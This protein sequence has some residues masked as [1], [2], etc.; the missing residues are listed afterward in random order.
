MPKE[1]SLCMI[2]K[3]EENNLKRCLNSVKDLV[4]EIIILD[5]GSTDNT[6]AIASEYTSKIFYYD[7][8]NDFSN[9]RNNSL[10]YATKDFIFIMDADDELD[11]NDR[12]K[13]FNLKN[14]LDDSETIYYFQTISHLS[15]AFNS[16]INS[17][18]NLMPRLFKNNTKY[19]YKNALHEQLKSDVP[20]DELRKAILDIHIFHYGYLED[21]SIDKIKFN[22]NIS[23]LEKQLLDEPNEP[24]HYFNLGNEY[25]SIRNFEEA[26]KY[27]LI[28]YKD[29]DPCKGYSP[30]LILKLVICY[31]SLDKAPECFDMIEKGLCIYPT[32]SD[33]HY[34]KGMILFDKRLYSQAIDEFSSCVDLGVAPPQLLYV[35]DASP[36]K[37]YDMISRCY[38]KLNNCS[39]AFEFAAKAIATNPKYV[40]PFY[41]C[42]KIMVDDNLSVDNIESILLSFF[43]NIKENSSLI[44]NIFYM[45]KLYNLSLKYLNIHEDNFQLSEEN[46]ILKIKLLLKLDKLDE[47][48]YYIDLISPDSINFF[49]SCK[50]KSILY[51]LK[52]ENVLAM[53]TIHHFS[54]AS[55][56]YQQK[57]I[58]VLRE[59]SNLLLHKKGS[60]I[61]D[62][63]DEI[64]SDIIFEILEFFL[65]T[66]KFDEF[67]K[68]LE[69]LNLIDDSS[70]LLRL[71]KL[72]YEYGYKNMAKKEILNSIK[73][74]DLID[75]DSLELLSNCF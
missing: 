2:V 63:K 9:A 10:K 35:K 27:F 64:I 8:C 50:L 54:V 66:H 42:V 23:I 61:C 43:D 33:L 11:P 29:F 58:T 4:D 36:L 40:L 37:S 7:W 13:F 14:N 28:S 34:I 12:D 67:E 20:L 75:K 3:N 52:H 59:A 41:N 53:K 25:C 68:L 74:F 1:I 56:T 71:A 51:L 45:S 70:V 57:V 62:T 16:Y 72:Y 21:S 48:I 73:N 69:L 60:P 38:H 18:T 15:Q 19:Y 47:S 46:I 17:S 44:S 5:T 32:F 6:V 39:K 31:Y 55:T 49:T 26:L 65:C 24:F 30:R 22:R